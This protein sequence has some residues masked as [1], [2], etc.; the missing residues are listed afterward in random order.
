[1]NEQTKMESKDTPDAYVIEI[2]VLDANDN[3]DF[4]YIMFTYANSETEVREISLERVKEKFNGEFFILD[5]R[6]LSWGNFYGVII[7]YT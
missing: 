4:T 1:M 3:K 5:V 2:E 6:K 7:D